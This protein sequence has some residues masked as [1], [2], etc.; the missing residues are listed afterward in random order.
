MTKDEL[1]EA[2]LEQD[3]SFT[4]CP[5]VVFD[6]PCLP[7][8]SHALL[9]VN[10]F[11]GQSNR[12]VVIHY[13]RMPVQVAR[14]RCKENGLSESVRIELLEMGVKLKDLDE[15]MVMNHTAA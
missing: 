3:D 8:R 12:V 13:Q 6:H 10:S 4:E 15:L 11:V 5:Q 9:G 14:S 7:L 1:I 2:V